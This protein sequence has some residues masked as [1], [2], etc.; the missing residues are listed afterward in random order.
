MKL[1][2]QFDRYRFTPHILLLFQFLFLSPWGQI[3]GKDLETQIR[4]NKQEST[5]LE[6][7]RTEHLK[8][9]KE[10]KENEGSV[11]NTLRHL[12][13][14][15][16]VKEGKLKRVR[17]QIKRVEKSI[18]KSKED[19]EKLEQEIKTD[20]KRVD[21]QIRAMF[22]LYKVRKLTLLPGYNSIKHHF[23]NQKILHLNT[24][25]DLNIIMRLKENQDLKTRKIDQLNKTFME[26]GELSLS[27]KEQRELLDFERE[28]QVTYLKHLTNN[29][30]LRYKYLHEIQL[31]LEKLN[32][33][34]YSLRQERIFSLR[35][36]NLRGFRKQL[37]NLPS[38]ATGEL[39]RPFGKTQGEELY[40]LYRRGVLVETPEDQEVVS[41]MD[42]K[43]VFSSP[44]KG[45][46]N[47]VIIDH[48]KRSFS[49]YGN[50]EEVYLQK[51]SHISQGEPV[52]VVA[53]NSRKKTYLFYFELRYKKKAVNPVKWL[54]QPHWRK[55]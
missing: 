22:Y 27:E 37:H 20:Q 15:I 42:G 14:S 44:F 13:A 30:K 8:L 51:N 29:Q 48:G 35:Q 46:E 2:F 1:R 7:Q 45:Y 26:L 47:L 32:D 21:Q 43:V 4:N 54:K 3:S 49:I 12:D 23:R 19:L 41:I 16:R 31:S 50:L 40:R 38:P 6:N 36:K 17:I 53:Y 39:V 55:L 5:R 10:S 28:Q 52:G 9:I 34:I 24:D 25:L 33:V 18:V 11:L